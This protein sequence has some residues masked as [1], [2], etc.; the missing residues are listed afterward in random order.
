[1]A[2]DLYEEPL[3]HYYADGTTWGNV[4]DGTKSKKWSSPSGAK[5]GPNGEPPADAQFVEQDWTGKEE[6][7]FLDKLFPMV[8]MAAIG[9]GVAGYGAALD[10][11]LG[12]SGMGALEAG[13]AGAA[14][15]GAATTAGEAALA[16]G[17]LSGSSAIAGDA[18]AAPAV[19]AAGATEG[20]VGSQIA[21]NAAPLVTDEL[22]FTGPAAE[23]AGGAL[24]AASASAP[25]LYGDLLKW[26]QKNQVLASSLTQAGVG[27]LKG[28]GD[29]GTALE[30]ADKKGRQAAD[31]RAQDAALK[32]ANGWTG[33]L[34]IKPSG[35]MLRRSDGTPVYQNGLIARRQ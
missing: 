34:P 17:A 4:L 5:A 21:Q 13:A 19:E 12:A 18:V 3:T 11:A 30:I 15:A 6:G 29:R 32:Q 27:L 23:A 10:S 25:S 20:L 9:G 1:M 26:A 14:G 16:D 2:D 22:A 35:A 31:L 7:G 24:H 8:V 33:T 28:I